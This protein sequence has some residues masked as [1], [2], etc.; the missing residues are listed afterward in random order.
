M[1]SSVHA[2]RRAPS[3]DAQADDG[4]QR[5]AIVGGMRGYL[6]ADDV[7][8]RAVASL[9]ERLGATLVRVSLF[10]SRA[11]GEADPDSDYDLLVVVEEPGSAAKQAVYE[12]ASDFLVDHR[13]DLSAKVL[14]R[15][16]FERLHRSDLPF[17]RRFAQ[18]EVVLWS[19]E[20]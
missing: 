17:W 20:N 1:P 11:R 18:D 12:V 4:Q 16:D 8:R 13:V 14:P 19:R 7:P 5:H 3:R 9:R 6:A 15:A 2:A 10:G